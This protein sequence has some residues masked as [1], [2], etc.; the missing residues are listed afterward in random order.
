M[1]LPMNEQERLQELL[2]Y[3]VLDTPAETELDELAQIASAICDTPISLVSLIDQDRQWFKA[4]VGLDVKET[5]RE[6][7]FCQHALHNPEEVLVVENSLQDQRFKENPLVLGDPHIRFYAGA[8]LKTPTGNVLGTLCI[9][10]NKPR[11]LS[12]K[13][14]NALKLLAKKAMDYLN[15]RK[16]LIHQS[17]H[18]ELSALK[19]KKLTD[20]APGV[21]YQFE[22]SPA[23]EMSFTFVSKGIA[24]LHPQLSVEKL[25]Q[26]PEIAFSI[27][28]PDDLST[29]QESIQ[30]SFETL[31]LWNVE[32]RIVLD[33]GGI[34]WHWGYAKPERKEDGTV[35]WYGTF[36]D[37]TNVKEYEEALEQISFDISHVL[38]RPVST[39]L[40]LTA[41]IEKEEMDEAG[42]KEYA[43][44]IKVVSEEL[45][46]FTRQLN[47]VYE[48]K[49]AKI[50]NSGQKE[51]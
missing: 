34:S 17:R 38:R 46:R 16:L 50:T 35:V 12:E 30:V 25:M 28:H 36:Q 27:V 19:L 47:E 41:I 6:D 8:P 9:I 20:Q 1:I 24:K 42:F 7:S 45:E 26:Q 5:P 43:G 2:N 39:M 22:M 44:Y 3:E 33:N 48:K 29:V 37:I 49:K 40:G 32:Y 21:I 15:D 51:R 18:I 31:T 10:D 14:K 4:S 11:K 23:G 13:Q